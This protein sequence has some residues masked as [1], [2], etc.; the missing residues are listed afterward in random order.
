[1]G[2]ER[3]PV[4]PRPARASA[5]SPL[6]GAILRLEHP[7][8]RAVS[9]RRWRQPI[10]NRPVRRQRQTLQCHRRAADIAAQPLEL[11]A[12]APPPRHAAKSSSPS[13]PPLHLAPRA[14]FLTLD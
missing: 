7:V 6:R 1:L 13:P 4:F 2:V 3:A 9:V 5:E 8:G 12:P 11:R 14:Q 10:A